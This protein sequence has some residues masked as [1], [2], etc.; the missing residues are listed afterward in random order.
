VNTV[1]QSALNEYGKSAAKKMHVYVFT[2]I[3]TKGLKNY[4]SITR[5][6]ELSYVAIRNSHI[7]DLN[8]INEIKKN[9]IEAIQKISIESGTKGSLVIDFT[10]AIKKFMNSDDKVT[11]DYDGVS[12]RSQKGL[13]IGVAAWSNNKITIPVD[14]EYWLRKKD[15][16]ERYIKKADIVIALI[17]ALKNVIPFETI[18]LDGAFISEQLLKFFE[19]ENLKYCIRIPSNRVVTSSDGISAKIRDHKAL[20]LT[21]NQ[22]YKSMPA[23]YKGLKTNIVAQKRKGKNNTK[24][25]VFIATN[26]DVLPKK[27][28]ETYA[29][30]WVIEKFNRTIKQRL[31]V[32]DCQSSDPA[33]QRTH[34][35]AVIHAYTILEHIRYYKKK[36]SVEE[37]LHILRWQKTTS[38]HPQYVDLVRTFMA[39]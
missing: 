7:E 28:V 24:E 33:K 9:Q 29:K 21:K 35:W 38:Q 27:C 34:V 14:I 10:F 2:L 39:F 8:Y 26:E 20:K 6:H 22:K 25:I 23:S 15:S 3:M 31:G 19:Q 37:V 18:L 5:E 17:L 13:S 36:K 11:Y 1:F 16:G 32:Q 30:R 12:K 4:S